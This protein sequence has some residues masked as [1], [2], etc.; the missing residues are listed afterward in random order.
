MRKLPVGQRRVRRPGEPPSKVRSLHVFP[1]F[2]F[3]SVEKRLQLRH[4]SHDIYTWPQ[5][6]LDSVSAFIS[7][8]YLVPGLWTRLTQGTPAAFLARKNL[9]TAPSTVGHVAGAEA[10]RGSISGQPVS[11]SSADD[12]ARPSNVS[13]QL[14]GID[15]GVNGGGAGL[16]DSLDGHVPHLLCKFWTTERPLSSLP[17]P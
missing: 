12:L 8:L 3:E 5:F 10:L 15:N 2:H 6:D 7:I 4:F 17:P 16:L 13:S 11:I 9:Y 14:S 1:G